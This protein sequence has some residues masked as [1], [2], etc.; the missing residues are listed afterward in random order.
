MKT[1]KDFNILAY[2]EWMEKNDRKS[3][4][5]TY[6]SKYKAWFKCNTCGFEWKSIVHNRS[7]GKGCPSCNN[8]VVTDNNRLS[9]IF[10]NIA[11]EW[12]PNNKITPDDYTAGSNKT[13]NWICSKCGHKW[14]ARI[15]DR[16]NGRGCLSCA[17]QIVN[18]SN[19]LS[20][21][22]P[23]SILDWDYKKNI[24]R[25]ENYTFKSNKHVW[26]K[27]SQC[28]FKWK[29][30]VASYSISGCRKCSGYVPNKTNDISSNTF[31]MEFFNGEDPSLIHRGSGKDVSWK[32]KKCGYVWEMSPHTFSGYRGC[33]KCDSG[34]RVS[35]MALMWILEIDEDAIPEQRILVDDKYIYVDGYNYDTGTIYEFFGDYWHGNPKVYNGNEINQTNKIRFGT[36][37]DKTKTRVDRIRKNGYNIVYI[38]EKEWKERK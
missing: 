14:K 32:C 20:T 38:W 37:Y 22:T 3:D 31:L 25:P 26:W 6:G 15:V 23:K 8:R 28:D 16:V 34:S 24:K 21:L 13:V 2:T 36:L 18:N 7:K 5:V 33:P 35:K 12:D 1:L 4:E 10:P 17:G 27:C 29:G 19:R 30:S 11:K 9:K